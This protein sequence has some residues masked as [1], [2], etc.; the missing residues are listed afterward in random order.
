[1][2]KSSP[3]QRA[4][5]VQHLDGEAGPVLERAAVFVGAL[6]VERARELGDEVAVAAVDHAHLD[7]GPLAAL[8]GGGVLLDG[9]VDLGVVH[10]DGG[11]RLPALQRGAPELLH[12]EG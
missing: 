1:M 9:L 4:D 12:G 5:P 3:Q 6:V 2:T 7:A 11:Q 8:G 10:L